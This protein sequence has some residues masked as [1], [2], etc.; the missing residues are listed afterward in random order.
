[1]KIFCIEL[2]VTWLKSVRDI[3]RIPETANIQSS[4]PQNP[5]EARRL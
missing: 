1:M 2:D 3:I 5:V 4:P